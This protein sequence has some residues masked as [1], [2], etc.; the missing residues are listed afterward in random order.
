MA[1][2]RTYNYLGEV[3]PPT[4]PGTRKVLPWG[5]CAISV[6]LVA[7]LLAETGLACYLFGQRGI[8]EP[9]ARLLMTLQI[10]S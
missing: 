3:L 8:G 4:T 2:N 6:T 10:K 7:L 9:D 5:T 1:K